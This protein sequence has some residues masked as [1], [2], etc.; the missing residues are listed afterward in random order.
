MFFSPPLYGVMFIKNGTI[1]ASDFIIIV[2]NFT[3]VNKKVRKINTK[4]INNLK[5]KYVT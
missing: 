4:Y 3:K 2:F 1:F 5:N